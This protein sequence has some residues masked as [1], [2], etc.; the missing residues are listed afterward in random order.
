MKRFILIT[1]RVI[2][3]KSVLS[4][5]KGRYPT[6][7]ARYPTLMRIILPQGV[8]FNFKGRYPTLEA[9]YPTLESR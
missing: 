1:K 2:P 3:P 6:L 8:L 7:E 4:N 5:F 9:R